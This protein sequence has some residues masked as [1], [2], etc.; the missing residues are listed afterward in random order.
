MTR[1]HVPVQP[2]EEQKED[3]F[4]CVFCEGADWPAMPAASGSALS[5]G[6]AESG[7]PL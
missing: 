3:G 6:P 2:I 4:L 1:E 5:S 7:Q